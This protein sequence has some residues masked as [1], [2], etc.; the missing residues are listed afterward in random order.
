MVR[1]DAEDLADV[2]KPAGADAIGALFRI[3]GPV[4]C[5]AELVITPS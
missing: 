2:L 5:D 3:F 4:E 1:F